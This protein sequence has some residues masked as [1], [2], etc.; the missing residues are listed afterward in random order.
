MPDKLRV[1]AAIAVKLLFKRKDNEGLVHILAQQPDPPLPPRPELR[2]NV[3]DNWNTAF[4]HL[5]RDAPVECGRINDDG[6]VR[7]ALV[8]LSD[9]LVKQPPDSWQMTQNFRDA[10]HGEVFRVNHG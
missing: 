10:D 7:L 9:E 3:I 8:S 1:H 5:P 4:L 6:K 2:A